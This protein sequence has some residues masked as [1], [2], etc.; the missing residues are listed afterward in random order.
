MIW[1][2]FTQEKTTPEAIKI[3]KGDGLYLYTKNGTRY[4]DMISSWWVNIHGHANKEIADAI[5]EQAHKLEQVIFTAFCHE[6]AEKLVDNLKTVLPKSLNKF[7]FSDNG[8]TS[9]EVALKM[10][11]Q[12]FKNQGNPDRKIY[13]H[14]EGSYHGDTYGAMSVSGKNSIYHFNFADFFFDTITI[15]VPEFY[16]DIEN[17]QQQED[18]IIKDLERRLD[19]VGNNV[20]A[21]IV[22]PLLQGARGMIL[23]RPE[24]LEKLIKTVRHFNILVIFDE[25]MTGFYRTGKFFAMDY[26][27]NDSTPDLICISKALTGGFLPLSLTI[28]TEQIYNTFLS[29][30]FSKSF[31]H[32]HSYTGNP[33]ACAAACKS[34]EILTRKETINNIK[35]IETMHKN[36]II[37]GVNKRRS[38][39]VMTAFDLQST[40]EANRITNELFKQG[41]FIRPLGKTI[42]LLPPYC[43]TEDELN[44]VYKRI[45][46]LI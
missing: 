41:I 3:I 17:I 23:Y 38:I 19:S 18:D 16:E 26:L 9:V 32:G 15:S 36:A 13:L 39:G 22:E 28:T 5:S 31:I 14:L 21:L 20:C 44:D 1:R 8:S 34:F 27:N 46:Q 25:V 24:F 7:F 12:F 35:N 29:D 43:I 33:I 40:Q 30:D 6:P 42:Y 45:K 4:A 37:D 11:Y 2:P 10:A